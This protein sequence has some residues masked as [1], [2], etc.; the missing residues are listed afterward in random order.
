M[1]INMKKV[2]IIILNYKGVNDTLSCLKSLHAIKNY[3]Y[4]VNILVVNYSNDGND[5]QKITNTYPSVNL[6]NKSGNLGFSKANNIGILKAL[7]L[8]ADYVLLLNNDTLVSLDFLDLLF[9]YLEENHKVAAV[10]P[11][12]YFAKGFEFH[13]KRYIAKDLGRVIWYAGGQIDWKNMYSSHRGVDEADHGQY[14]D[15]SE[16]D[17]ISGCCV[18]IR[19]SALEQIGLLNEDLFLYWEDTDWSIRA[20]RLDWQLKIFPKAY[21]WHKN[22]SS[23][24]SGSTLQDYYLTR[25][26]LWIGMHYA[27]IRTKFALIRQSL[28]QLINGRKWEKIGVRDFWLG[29]MG[30][31]SWIES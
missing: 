28:V 26:R 16:T 11:K 24:S 2:A 21:I 30:K 31:G 27:P 7:K 17:H 10:S 25:N 15:L 6:I 8:G 3:N 9:H 14:D 20:K 23:S 29:K 13:K 19:K 1:I 18:L 12:I 5:A 22:A 4:S